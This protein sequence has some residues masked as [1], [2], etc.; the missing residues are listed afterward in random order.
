[1]HVM[2]TSFKL[3]P[4][5]RKHAI[6]FL[7]FYAKEKLSTQ[8]NLFEKIQEFP[9]RFVVDNNIAW[10][11]FSAASENANVAFILGTTVDKEASP[12]WGMLEDVH[13]NPKIRNNVFMF[14][15]KSPTR[16]DV[17]AGHRT[18]LLVISRLDESA[19][20]LRDMERLRKFDKPNGD[21]AKWD[22]SESIAD[23]KQRVLTLLGVD[24]IVPTQRIPS[25]QTKDQK[26]RLSIER[27]RSKCFGR[28]WESNDV[29]RYAYARLLIGSRKARNEF[30]EPAYPNVFGDRDVIQNAL[31]FNADVLCKDEA[32]KTM[33]RYCG[34]QPRESP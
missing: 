32:V 31:F 16:D 8:E 24:R 28:F 17:L 10:P 1:M 5:Y 25:W 6:T 19:T 9:K 14:G 21:K 30:V 34:I 26:L 2:P 18:P 7:T 12:L 11:K 15:M 22:T 23:E 29:A 27:D 33:A 13:K 4:G 3:P 20:K